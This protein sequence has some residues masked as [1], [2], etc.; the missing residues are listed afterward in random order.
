MEGTK[1]KIMAVDDSITIRK[2]AE[3][4]LTKEGFI[5]G[6]AGT[7]QEF[8]NN[9]AKFKPDLVL[10]DFVLP[11]LPSDEICQQLLANEETKKVPILM[12]SSNGNAIRNMYQSFP[13]VKDYLTK[14]FQ[15]SV[16]SSVV[17]HVLEKTR[18]EAEEALVEAPVAAATAAAETLPT[19]AAP[20]PVPAEATPVAVPAPAIEIPLPSGP[21]EVPSDLLA[22]TGRDAEA[23]FQARIRQ[24]LSERFAS[25][26]RNIPE[27]EASRAGKDPLEYYLSILGRPRVLAELSHALQALHMQ[28]CGPMPALA[29]DTSIMGVDNALVHLADRKATGTLLIGI[30]DEHIHIHLV[31]GKVAGITSNNP[32]AYCA[33]ADF[34]FATLDRDNA[35][36]AVI[37]QKR[38]GI[39]F[40]ASLVHP[41]L[42]PAAKLPAILAAQGLRALLR[43]L[44]APAAEYRFHPAAVI[45]AWAKATSAETEV[46]TLLLEVYRRLD[47]WVLIE[48]GIGGLEATLGGTPKKAELAERISLTPVEKEI[49]DLIDGRINNQQVVNWSGREEFEVGSILYRLL[50]M[51]LLEILSRGATRKP[52]EI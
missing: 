32:K 14:P 25:V 44:G 20:A 45:P 23:S 19:P 17:R 49:L 37:A 42:L 36:K 22:G 30:P 43:A 48:G 6:L 26:A 10:L 15:P 4:I 1:Q 41:G 38:H 8:L 51:G 11:D 34:D 33:G 52:D 29:G 50:K 7:G 27:L 2:F 9:V 16:L 24:V 13:N 28:A 40:F 12:I 47:N 18:K 35:I 31:S 46:R 39:P 21:V 5:V 3:T